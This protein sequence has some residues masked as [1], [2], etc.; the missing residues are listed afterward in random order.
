MYSNMKWII[1]LLLAGFAVLGIASAASAQVRIT[2]SLLPPDEARDIFNAGQRLFDQGRLTDAESRFREVIR[3]FPKNQIADRADYYLIRSLMAQSG[4]KPEALSL[5]DGFAKQYPKSSWQNDVLELRIQLTNQVPETFERI[6][7]TPTPAPAPGASPGGR[8]IYISGF[9]A[10]APVPPA[11]PAPAAAPIGPGSVGPFGVFSAAQSSDP[12]VSLQQEVM[13][14]IFQSNADRAIEIAMER[15]KA[16]PGD[17]VVLA[18]MNMIASSRSAQAMPMLISIAK[19]STNA[20][21][22]KDAIYWLGQS[23]IGDRDAV[24]DTLVSL[25]PSLSEEDS[26]AV[27]YS[28]SQIRSDKSI[29]ALATIARD[30][31]KN[32]KLRTSVVYWIGQTRAP[33][34][35]ALLEDIYKNSTDNARIRGQIANALSQTREPQAITILGNMALSDP[36]IEVRKQAVYWLG[37]SRSPEAS[38]ALEQLL[39]RK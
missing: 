21:A 18:S 36:D 6:L 5:I 11:P 28:L 22:R 27:A 9:P 39:Q 29:S 37:Q 16:N 3:R 35:V 8:P 14:A 26:E 34:R 2:Q 15:L 25:L 38:K 23:R 17:P 24:V 32:E 4:K 31:G 19:S 7:I 1:K 10:P 13:R 20:R 33:N 30:K 12:E